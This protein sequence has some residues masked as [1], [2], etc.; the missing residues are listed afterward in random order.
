MNAIWGAC[1]FNQATR[2]KCFKTSSESHDIP[3]VI[4][5]AAVSRK[6]N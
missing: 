2:K 5:E 4:L 6:K 1:S 3:L